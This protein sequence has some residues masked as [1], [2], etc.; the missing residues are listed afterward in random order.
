MENFV[1]RERNFPSTE[2]E[3]QLRRDQNLVSP[4]GKLRPS[5]QMFAPYKERP[6]EVQGMEKKPGDIEEN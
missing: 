1:A 3:F 5:S 2:T 6:Q 4:Y